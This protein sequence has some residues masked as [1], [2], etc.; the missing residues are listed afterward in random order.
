MNPKNESKRKSDKIDSCGTL[1]SIKYDRTK[2]VLQKVGR[3]LSKKQGTK[4]WN[5]EEGT[6]YKKSE[7]NFLHKIGK[8]HSKKQGR[9]LWN[10]EGDIDTSESPS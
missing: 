3:K 9:K 2:N 8:K 1:F 10:E 4:H 6:F 7:G 5:K